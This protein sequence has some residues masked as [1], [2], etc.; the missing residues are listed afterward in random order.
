MQYYTISVWDFNKNSTFEVLQRCIKVNVKC[1]APCYLAHPFY[2]TACF[3]WARSV[4]WNR[5]G[6][7]LMWENTRLRAAADEDILSLLCLRSLLFSCCEESLDVRISLPL[8]WIKSRQSQPPVSPAVSANNKTQWNILPTLL[9]LCCKKV[10][11]L[12]PGLQS[13]MHGSASP[14][15]LNTAEC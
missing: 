3:N 9:W 1:K 5:S 4:W 14:S 13:A 11:D 8:L 6:H 7:T 10:A 12:W 2:I 15:L